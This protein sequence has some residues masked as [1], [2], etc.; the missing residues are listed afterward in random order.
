VARLRAAL[1]IPAWGIA[2][3]A[4]AVLGSHGR[5]A[6]ARATYALASAPTGA[7]QRYLAARQRPPDLVDDL[8]RETYEAVIVRAQRRRPAPEPGR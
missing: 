2:A 8:L 4:L 3:F 7:V 6:V 5:A 1:H